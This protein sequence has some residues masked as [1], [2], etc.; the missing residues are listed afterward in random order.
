MEVAFRSRY[1]FPL[2][3][4]DEEE[5]DP[6]EASLKRLRDIVRGRDMNFPRLE[7]MSLLQAS[8]FP[9]KHR[10]FESLLENERESPEI[11]YFAALKLAE[12][13]TPA[14]LQIL[15]KNT[16]LRDEHA[17]AGVMIALGQIGDGSALNAILE[18]K[19]YAKAFAEQQA[20]FAAALICHRLGLEGHGLAYPDEKDYL[21]VPEHA[22]R[23]FQ[24]TGADEA[25]AGF[26]L[27][28]IAAQPF[29]IELAERPM[30]QVRCGRTLQMIML[31]R[32]LTGED[33]VRILSKRKTFLGV[34]ATRTE[35]TEL[36]SI[37]FLLLTSPAKRPDSINILVP[38]TTGEPIFGGKA[39]IQGN[40]T[41]FSI[42]SVS[43]PGAFAIK[44]EGRFEHGRLVMATA[45]SGLF[46]EKKR[47]PL[48]ERS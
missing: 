41:E 47:H 29:G 14:A 44:I 8:D 18:A 9:C 17:L 6:Q 46:V 35:G 23:P 1:K 20:E 21:E 48:R 7:A 38:R 26:C 42:G 10:D 39:R 13:N 27:R 2:R 31:N 5:I 32:D 19:K 36:Y 43:R 24:V 25:E 33:A 30:Y 45:L 37:A 12:I 22:C 11:R 4:R 28:S 16:Q 3:L 15:T 34:I 40:H